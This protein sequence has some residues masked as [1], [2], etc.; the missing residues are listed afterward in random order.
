MYKFTDAEVQKIE[1]LNNK[2]V[3]LEE[4]LFR[5]SEVEYLRVKKMCEDTEQNMED[6]N[7][8][9]VLAFSTTDEEDEYGDY[10]EFVNW[11][12]R[13]YFDTFENDSEEPFGINDKYDWNVM[14]GR[15]NNKK[16][17]K[18]KHCWLL[19]QLYDNHFVSWENMLRIDRVWFEIVTEQEYAIKFKEL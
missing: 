15:S 9:V 8:N 2:L 17:D 6:Y 19:H 12:E 11:K 16:L 3:L 5:L 14:V 18:Q 7:L 1:E 10:L 4:K 13:I